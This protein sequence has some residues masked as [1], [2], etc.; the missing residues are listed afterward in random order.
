MSDENSFNSIEKMMEFGMSMA[1]A[2]QM[3]QTMNHAMTNMQMPQFN[4]LSAPIPTPM[5]KQFYALVNDVP[6]GPFTE[7]EL[8]GHI[9]AGR[10]IKSTMVW[11]QGMPCW[12]PAEQVMEVNKLFDLVP[13]PIK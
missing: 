7:T 12:M 5:P 8:T 6:Q 11:L 1:V 9:I 4:N 3:M 13:P 2:Q 10:V